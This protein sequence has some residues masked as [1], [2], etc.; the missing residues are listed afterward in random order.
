VSYELEYENKNIILYLKFEKLNKIQ[1][2]PNRKPSQYFSSEMM[3]L[4]YT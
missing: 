2:N 3:N 1:L 4:F